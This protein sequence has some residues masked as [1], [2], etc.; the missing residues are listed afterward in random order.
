MGGGKD[1]FCLGRWLLSYCNPLSLL[2]AF[3]PEH[4]NKLMD[5]VTFSVFISVGF[6][7]GLLFLLPFNGLF[8]L[9]LLVRLRTEVVRT[10]VL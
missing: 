6:Q 3:L 2:F 10:Q 8:F 1:G 5:F 9:F 4:F 7:S